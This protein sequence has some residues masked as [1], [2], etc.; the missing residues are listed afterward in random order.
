MHKF[1]VLRIFLFLTIF[2]FSIT[3]IYSSNVL[4]N[5]SSST[6]KK[7]K[8]SVQK[9][10]DKSLALWKKFDTKRDSM[11]TLN[12]S[13]S[14]YKSTLSLLKST[15]QA[16]INTFNS[17]R[18]NLSCYSAQEVTYISDSYD[19]TIDALSNLNKIIKT[20][21]SNTDAKFKTM[22]ETI[23]L[24]IAGEYMN[25]YSLDGRSF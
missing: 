1:K 9:L 11:S 5:P 7:L 15:Y 17:A 8:L 20:S 23:W 3:V 13:N 25:F 6:C 4:A 14:E 24:W 21:A 2:S 18:K 12:F 10:D 22:K 16:D 19:G